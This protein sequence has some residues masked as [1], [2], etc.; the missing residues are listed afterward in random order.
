MVLLSFTLY[1]SY[2]LFPFIIYF[3]NNLN[4]VVEGIILG[5]LSL[6][7]FFIAD[8]GMNKLTPFIKKRYIIYFILLLFYFSFQYPFLFRFAL[9][10]SIL[11]FP[12]VFFSYG[13]IVDS[14]YYPLTF[15]KNES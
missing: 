13:I 6:I 7:Y 11:S 5:T 9:R 4:R 8:I 10:T 3:S 14:F 15:L 2:F 12:R 1:R